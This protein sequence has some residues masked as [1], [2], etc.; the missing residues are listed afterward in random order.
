MARVSSVPADDPVLALAIDFLN[1]Y[2][3]LATPPDQ[4]SVERVTAL[5]SRHGQAAVALRPAD[6]DAV[7]RLRERLRPAFADP[8]LA[9]KVAA[10][11]AVLRTESTGTTLA[12]DDAGTVTLRASGGAGPVG[13]LGV[14]LADALARALATSGADRFG[15]CAASPCHCVYVDRTRS[16][17]QRFCC[18]LCNDRMAAAAYRRRRGSA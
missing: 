8:S 3:D 11:D 16:G 18:Q 13:R 1:T 15:T 7:R 12:L 14:L 17:R 6:L 4:L 2:D 9:G 5:L 10:L